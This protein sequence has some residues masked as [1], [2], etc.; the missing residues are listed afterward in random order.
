MCTDEINQ[1]EVILGQ[2]FHVVLFIT[3]Y[4]VASIFESVDEILSVTIKMKANIASFSHFSAYFSFY[5]LGY[6]S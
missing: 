2:Y 1:M 6:S 3:L 4:K 5:L